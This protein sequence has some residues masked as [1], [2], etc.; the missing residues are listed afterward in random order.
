M[1][2][3]SRFLLFLGI[4]ATTVGVSVTTNLEGQ[5]LF[6]DKTP[7]NITTRITLNNA[8]YSTYSRSDGSFVIYDVPP[9]IHQLDV[10][11][12]IFHFGQV[13]VQLLEESLD[14]PNCLE[15]AYPGAAKT[16]I[17]YPLEL[18]AHAT[19]DYYEPKRGFSIFGLLKNPMVL[20]M[21]VSA[22]LMVGMPK[23]MEGLDPEEKEQMRKQMAAQSNPTEML[24]Q[25]FNMGGDNAAD[26]GKTRRERR[27]A[28]KD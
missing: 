16:A 17:K 2:S 26:A 15:Y 7:F 6:P 8:E 28:K 18:I 14:A 9:G 12:T 10:Q 11:S 4:I 19:Y 3:V 20:M 22:G 21:L 24:S 25:M 5:L 23:L 1:F 13:K 27:R